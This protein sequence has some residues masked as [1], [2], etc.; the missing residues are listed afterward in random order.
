M[1]ALRDACEQAALQGHW[2]LPFKQSRLPAPLGSPTK[3]PGG[4][5][6]LSPLVSPSG[7]FTAAQRP[8]G[9]GISP[10]PLA[11]RA[12]SGSLPLSPTSSRPMSPDGLGG[13]LYSSVFVD[14]GVEGLLS[15]S[16]PP[17]LRLLRCGSAVGW[18]GG[19][20]QIKGVLQQE[21]P[22]LKTAALS[23][24]PLHM[25][26]PTPWPCRQHVAGSPN[27]SQGALLEGPGHPLLPTRLSGRSPLSIDTRRA[28]S[29]QEELGPGEG[30]SSLLLRSS[31]AGEGGG[32]GT[33]QQA[34][35]GSTA[36][37][38]VASAAAVAGMQRPPLPPQQQAQ[39][40][41]GQMF[42]PPNSPRRRQTTFGATLDFVETLCQA[43]ASLTAFQRAWALRLG[44]LLGTLLVSWASWAAACPLC[45]PCRRSRFPRRRSALPLCSRRPAVGAAP[46]SAA[47]QCGD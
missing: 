18:A 25:H 29:L 23:S 20:L 42:S 43:S 41:A 13:G 47:D 17:D 11:R 2:Q 30:V 36:P 35:E 26:A 21:T 46:R 9:W 8:Q 6:A 38:S 44:W 7:S 31:T 3:L 27:A 34:D 33:V 10:D 15:G 14:T 40:Q 12:A 24:A 1:A 16:P 37:G 32:P 4:G 39:A 22:V 45:L 5:P 28:S 19:A